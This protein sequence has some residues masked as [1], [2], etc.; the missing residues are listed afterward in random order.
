MPAGPLGGGIRRKKQSGQENGQSR[1]GGSDR[2]HMHEPSPIARRHMLTC[3]R[4]IMV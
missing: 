4:C 3:P 1:D 2:T